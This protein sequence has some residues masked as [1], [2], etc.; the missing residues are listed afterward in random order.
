MTSPSQEKF[1]KNIVVLIPAHNESENIEKTISLASKYL[2]VWVVDDGSSD[3]T[4]EI[5]EKAGAKVFRQTP[6]QGKGVALRNGF[7]QAVEAG[8]DGVITLDGD[9]QHDPEEI[10]GFLAEL[11]S[12]PVDLII[13]TRKFRE[14]P[15]PR[16][17]S[18]AVG[19]DLYNLV[20]GR[21]IQDNQSGYRYMS[22]RL[23]EAALQSNQRGFEFEV[24]IITICVRRSYVLSEIPIK[25][26][27]FEEGKSHIKPIKHILGFFRLL[28]DTFRYPTNK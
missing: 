10:P 17:Y 27:Y 25:T 18:N 24:E 8:L 28:W 3:N 26:I 6:N 11:E 4:A 22:R 5:A 1:H 20:L 14:M 12:E 21:K 2:P 15:F 9:G 19:R 16:K 23:M 13:G 7:L